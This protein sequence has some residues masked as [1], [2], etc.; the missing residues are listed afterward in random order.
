ML[1][2][3]TS[4]VDNKVSVKH[5]NK[6]LYIYKIVEGNQTVTGKLVIE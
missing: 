2:N 4:L 5:L 1:V 3:E 6:G